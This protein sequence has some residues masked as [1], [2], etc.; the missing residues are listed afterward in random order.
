VTGQDQYNQ[1]FAE[2]TTVYDADNA[3]VGTIYEND[4][5]QGYIVVQKGFLFPRDIFIPTSAIQ[6]VN[7][8]GIYLNL[9]QDDLNDDRFSQ[10]PVV[11]SGATT[12]G[13]TTNTYGATTVGQTTAA[14]TQ[15]TDADVRVPVYEENLVAGK[16][17][18]Q[19]GEVHL[20]KDVV[21]EQQTVSVPLQ[22]ERVYVDRVAVNEAAPANVADAFQ[23]EDISVPVKGEQ[24]VIGKQVQ[25]VE[26]VRL[27]KDVTT[28]NQQVSDTVRKERVVVDD[29]TGTTSATS[30][31]QQ[32]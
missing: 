19:T 29:A 27:H 26:E 2:G 1:Q 3:K 9:R 18:Q 15:T 28:E 4:A 20:H 32:S 12:V 16:Q 6:S 8:D 17:E 25:E 5:D 7:Q 21:Q 31:T 11:D 30:G 22:Q 24:A 23:S 13:Q 10:V 14:T